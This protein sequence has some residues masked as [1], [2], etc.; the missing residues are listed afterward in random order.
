MYIILLQALYDVGS[1]LYLFI[2][3]FL[4]LQ[5]AA[6][7]RTSFELK[8]QSLK[9]PARLLSSIIIQTR[10][11]AQYFGKMKFSNIT[12]ELEVVRISQMF[13]F[14]FFSTFLFN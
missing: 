9:V 12:S 1:I 4:K 11:N 5:Q 8:M 14:Y 6:P 10:K 3:L 7:F 2:L 13:F